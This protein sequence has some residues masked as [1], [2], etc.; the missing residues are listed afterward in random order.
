MLLFS[1]SVLLRWICLKVK[2]V[3][4]M[5]WIQIIILGYIRQS[6]VNKDIFST[7]FVTQKREKRRLRGEEEGKWKKREEFLVLQLSRL[8]MS[9][10]L[11][12]SH[13]TSEAYAVAAFAGVSIFSFAL[14]EQIKNWRGL[15]L[16][17]L[18]QRVRSCPRRYLGYF[19][20]WICWHLVVCIIC[21]WVGNTRTYLQ[22]SSVQASWLPLLKWLRVVFTLTWNQPQNMEKKNTRGV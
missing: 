19:S 7:Y 22:A 1:S 8:S 11:L 15:C 16:H 12:K 20:P 10:T 13:Y 6:P 14:E 5:C 2:Y 21:G 4:G 17:N 18:K 9:L 3:S